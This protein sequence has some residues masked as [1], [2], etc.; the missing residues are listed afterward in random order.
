MSEQGGRMPDGFIWGAATASYQI[1]GAV[2]E[3]GRG[4]SIWDR[5]S[6]TPG[7]VVNG[8]TGDAAADHY[9]RTA[10]DIALMRELGL[11]AYRFSLAW[12]RIL[13]AGT[14][15][16]NER[17]LDFYDRLVD[18][19]LAAG[20]TP[21]VTLYHWDLPQAL[22]ERGGWANRDTVTAFR[23]YTEVVA[24]RL[25]DRVRY[26]ITH[27]E[28]WV[29]AFL[30]NLYGVHAPGLTD[31]PTALA[32]AHHLLLS[33]GEAV[34][35]FRAHG[36]PET[37]VGI[38]L[39]LN[40]VDSASDSAPDR[41]AAQRMD[42]GL[43]RWFLDPV[44]RGEYPA[45]ALADFAALGAKPPIQDGDLARIAV[46][47]DF[48]GVNNYFRSLIQAGPKG[49]GTDDIHNVKAPGA[50]YTAM[51]W[52]VYPDGL[53]KLLVRLHHDYQ[54]AALYITENGAAYDDVLTAEDTVH[55]PER[56]AYLRDH[57][58]AARQAIAEGAP[59]RG[60]F[61]WSLLDNFE[62]AQGYAKRFGVI[63]VDY[64]TQR[65]IMKDSGRYY[66]EVIRANGPV[67]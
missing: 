63:Y 59:L 46:P 53:R 4:E 18:D 42:S 58:R 45:D 19:L 22:Q 29:A 32:V 12:P 66:A 52:E 35:V 3:D 16:V 11:G 13:P 49:D 44:F 7:K 25:G 57:L 5:F 14:G 28:P 17:G 26:W 55:D 43:N 64:P 15:A 61:V 39:N 30:G 51:G 27:N 8:D 20:I 2:A 10:E 36:T 67:E 31:L 9:H 41:A 21:F 40:H 65:R 56:V 47:I 33:H 23:R 54:P 48:L 38:T 1:E 60:Y 6:H 50:H 34:P 62:W 24:R 37:Q